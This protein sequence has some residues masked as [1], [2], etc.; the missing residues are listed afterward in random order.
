VQVVIET[1][2]FSHINFVQNT[3]Y[4]SLLRDKLIQKITLTMQD[5]VLN[6]EHMFNKK[7]QNYKFVLS[8]GSQSSIYELFNI[9]F[10]SSW[11]ME[12]ILSHGRMEKKNY[13]PLMQ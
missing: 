6:T 1:V 12:N 8:D 11:D 3:V 7:H 4:G 2:S 13:V 5:N 9:L 10:P